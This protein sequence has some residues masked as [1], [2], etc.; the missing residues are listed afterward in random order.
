MFSKVLVDRA[1]ELNLLDKEDFERRN[2]Q[3]FFPAVCTVRPKKSGLESS[4]ND[5][6]G[7]ACRLSSYG[8]SK[9]YVQ[10]TEENRTSHSHGYVVCSR[11]II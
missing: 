8:R 5:V 10:H 11:S 7:R 3:D 1:G 2:Q 4:Q 9:L 6:S